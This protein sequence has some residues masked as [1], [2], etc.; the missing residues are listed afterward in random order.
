[1]KSL[2][3]DA[4][5]NIWLMGDTSITLRAQSIF[6]LFQNLAFQ[7]KYHKEAINKD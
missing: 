7:I 1:M 5:S 3:K 6:L 4:I 2:I